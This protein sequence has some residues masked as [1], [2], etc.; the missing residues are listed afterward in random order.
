MKVTPIFLL[1]AKSHDQ[2]RIKRSGLITNVKSHDLRNQSKSVG[3]ASRAISRD[4]PCIRYVAHHAINSGLSINADRFRPLTSGVTG[5]MR[6][7]FELKIDSSA[8]FII[9]V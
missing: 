7:A 4:T 9:E 2:F 1:S 3:D 5:N 6:P 8:F